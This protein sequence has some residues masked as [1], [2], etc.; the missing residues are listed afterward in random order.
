MR[1]SG[2]HVFAIQGPDPPPAP[3]CPPGSG[4]SGDSLDAALAAALCAGMERRAYLAGRVRYLRDW[5]C[6]LELS[7]ALRARVWRLARAE[8]WPL[9]SDD[10]AGL[11]ELA[12]AE[13]ADPA[14]WG[15]PEHR[16]RW[17]D[18][19]ARDWQARYAKRYQAAWLI[20]S[21]WADWA[22]RYVSW[23]QT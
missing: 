11:C 20:L 18:I 15:R 2:A 14:R 8:R 1:H 21:D 16:A 4:H 17:A 5:S 23:R 22:A 10:I 6:A 12:V 13:L 7:R 19:S 9:D 3:D